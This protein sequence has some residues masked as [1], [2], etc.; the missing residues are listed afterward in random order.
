MTIICEDCFDPER[1]KGHN[2]QKITRNGEGVC[3]C[4]NQNLLDP[5][6]FCAK[7]KG[8]DRSSL[9]PPP[10][11]KRYFEQKYKEKIQA[12]WVNH[13]FRSLLLFFRPLLELILRDST[14]GLLYEMTKL[15]FETVKIPFPDLNP[16]H[17][18]EKK[19]KSELK[20]FLLK[21]IENLI[22]C[23]SLRCKF[24]NLVFSGSRSK[25]IET[26]IDTMS[27]K[28]FKQLKISQRHSQTPKLSTARFD[29]N[30]IEHRMRMQGQS[31][32]H[33]VQFI[34]EKRSQILRETAERLSEKIDPKLQV[35][36]EA[37]KNFL[38]MEIFA[39]VP[40]LD[41]AEFEANSRILLS[42]FTQLIDQNSKF[43]FLFV[44]VFRSPIYPNKLILNL[45]KRLCTSLFDVQFQLMFNGN[46]LANQPI[47]QGLM[48]RLSM[49]DFLP[50]LDS[51]FTG[52]PYSA[53][54]SQILIDFSSDEAFCRDFNKICLRHRLV[55]CHSTRVTPEAK[56]VCIMSLHTTP[57]SDTGQ[58]VMSIK[59]DQFW[60][61]FSMSRYFVEI[62][63]D[64]GF[65]FDAEDSGRVLKIKKNIKHFVVM[66]S[67]MEPVLVET[68]SIRSGFIK[69]F[70]ERMTQMFSFYHPRNFLEF[71]VTKYNLDF[72]LS[73]MTMCDSIKYNVSFWNH[74]LS[75]STRQEVVVSW[76][77]FHT[78]FFDFNKSLFLNFI[79]YQRW[80][81]FDIKQFL[82]L[83][84]RLLLHLAQQEA[85]APVSRMT[86]QEGDYE[87]LDLV[88]HFVVQFVG[89]IS[90]YEFNKAIGSQVAAPSF[91][92]ADQIF[93][94][95]Q[96]FELFKF[97]ENGS[98]LPKGL[99]FGKHQKT[100]TNNTDIFAASVR[101]KGRSSSLE[102]KWP[103]A[104]F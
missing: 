48:K 43:I 41:W 25:E 27:R 37:F 95:F 78:A 2:F 35:K 5:K 52:S 21:K 13:L 23:I 28:E 85:S 20:S 73:L 92:S 91:L 64:L 86:A 102:S 11:I 88:V 16:K 45:I 24:E 55:L 17:K 7:H 40:R 29:P 68:E 89:M 32:E 60:R 62:L 26:E 53:L 77:K 100:I 63:R 101:K 93:S 56:S 87:H 9:Q 103:E 19:Q 67:I 54:L 59:K 39:G 104:D 84:P 14:V 3:D 83:C 38:E 82:D 90:V 61:S 80:I 76:F 69:D 79:S 15:H 31:M 74:D 4:G 12:V 18:L 22:G 47:T 50:F 46:G 99:N 75:I 10:K 57:I 70:F 94:F 49:L 36:L 1:H 66:S 44:E 71:L 58:F 42:Q 8:L 72:V 34:R 98:N 6:G 65:K 33:T 96:N 81:N 97:S 51:L 30:I